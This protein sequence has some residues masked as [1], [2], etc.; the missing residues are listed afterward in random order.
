MPSNFYGLIKMKICIKFD[1]KK[2]KKKKK[3]S[4]L[5]EKYIELLTR[6]SKY[7]TQLYSLNEIEYVFN[8]PWLV[9][10]I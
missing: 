8:Y 2:K 7:S 6:E 9:T 10:L 1:M 4:F 3:I 5:F